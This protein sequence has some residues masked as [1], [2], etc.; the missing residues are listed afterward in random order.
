MNEYFMSEQI[1][2]SQHNTKYTIIRNVLGRLPAAQRP[3]D[4]V[5]YTGSLVQD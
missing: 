2:Q 1:N 3:K 4:H 5:V